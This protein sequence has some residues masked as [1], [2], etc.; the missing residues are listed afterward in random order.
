MES[1][2]EPL[3]EKLCREDASCTFFQT[4]SWH[5]I[6]ARHYGAESVP[7]LFRFG[8]TSA[9]LPLLKKRRWGRD[10]FF[11]PFGTY[12][13]LICSRNLDTQEIQSVANGLKGLNVQLVSSPYTSNPLVFGKAISSKTQ[14]I[15]LTGLDPENPMRDWDPDQR[16]RALL[17]RKNG[18]VI[19]EARSLE[20]WER[21]YALYELSV[22]RWGEKATGKYPRALFD[23]IRSMLS[24]SAVMRLWLTEHEGE[25]GAGSLVFYHNNKAL[26]WHGAADQ[27]FFSLG[28]TQLLYLHMVETAMQYHCEVLDLM[29]SAGLASLESFK[30]KFGASTVE[31][32]MSLNRTGLVSLLTSLVR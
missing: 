21:Y 31:Y 16:R 12:T 20:D 9:C 23:D 27:R 26:Y 8:E 24:G 22:Q 13:A 4:P 18:V 30:G 25:I 7:L 15:D 2:P 10:V 19:R 3:W 29:G 28:A 11:S 1:C 5:R 14:M 32:N 6:A 17:A